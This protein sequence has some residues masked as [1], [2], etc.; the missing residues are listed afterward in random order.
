MN[1]SSVE[2]LRQLN[3]IRQEKIY[4]KLLEKNT[5]Y[6]LNDELENEL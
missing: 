3:K 6:E 2:E 5:T 1:V 4:K